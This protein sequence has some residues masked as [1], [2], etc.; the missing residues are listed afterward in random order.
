MQ[1]R[2]EGE[3]EPGLKRDSREEEEKRRESK[4]KRK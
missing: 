1:Q 3:K 4:G 2:K